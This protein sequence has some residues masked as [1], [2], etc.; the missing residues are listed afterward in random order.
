[1]TRRLLC[2]ILY[3]C[4]ITSL[5][6]NDKQTQLTFGIVP[7]QSAS[8][9]AAKWGPVL[10]RWSEESGIQMKFS[11]AKNIPTFEQ[12]LAA[13]E[14]DIAYMNPYH[15]VSFSESSGY[16]ALVK[17]KDKLLKGIIVVRNDSPIEDISQLN[18]KQ[19]AF[20]APASFAATI[21]PRAV[22]AQNQIKIKPRFVYSHD[23][24]YLAVARGFSPAG[25]GVMRTFNN[26]PPEVRE[27]LKIVW[28][29]PGYTPHAIATHPGIDEETR[30]KLLAALIVLNQDEAFLAL[31]KE[32]NFKPF[33]MATHQDWNSVKELG[34]SG[35]LAQ[36]ASK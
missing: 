31:I 18:G 15:Y 12:R 19:I 6:A 20:P 21:I 17:E 4:C 26:T 16:R 32:L 27:L 34:I 29:S 36:D 1:M 22:L 23:S 24:V 30:E 2:L 8:K 28:T 7:Q 13:G 35:F 25:G 3:C 10:S 9:L 5:L 33:E 11:T 14:Y